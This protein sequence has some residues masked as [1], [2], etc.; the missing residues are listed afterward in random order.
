MV[1]VVLKLIKPAGKC[2]AQLYLLVMAFDILLITKIDYKDHATRSNVTD[3][4]ESA[5]SECF[6]FFFTPPRNRGGVIFSFQFVCVSVSVYYLCPAV[7]FWCRFMTKDDEV[8][9]S[10]KYYLFSLY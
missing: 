8:S 4:E 5:F 9:A 1:G 6:L 3:V 2:N 10:F 7:S